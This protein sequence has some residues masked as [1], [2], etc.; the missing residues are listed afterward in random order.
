M[1][2]DVILP[3]A[4]QGRRMGAEINKQYLSLL[5]K[6]VLA[7]TIDACLTSGVF[8][9]IIVVVTPG[10][11]EIFRRDVLLPWFPQAEIIVVAGGRERQDS[12]QNALQKVGKDAEF[13]CVHDGARPL[14]KPELFARCIK[15]AA[16]RGAAIA[17]VPVK[18][19]IKVIGAEGNVEHTPPRHVLRSVQTPQA[20]RRDWFEDAYRQATDVGFYATDDAALLEQY[21]Y[22]VYVVQGDY[23]NIKV[24]TPEDLVLAAVLLGRRHDAD[25]DR[26]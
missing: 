25:W 4:G 21:G 11:E 3:A 2:A 9:N 1:K 26:L 14:V 12:V 23:E 24:T 20:F 8:E 10:E 16:L 22:P 13:I 6:P 17:A 18:D 19:T 5:G 7:H 15:E